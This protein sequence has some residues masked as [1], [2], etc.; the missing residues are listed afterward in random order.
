[1]ENK[2]E[3]KRAKNFTEAEKIMLM[4]ITRE[5]LTIIENRKTD[6]KTVKVKKDTWE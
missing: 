3:V 6:T 2:S 1:M 5:F 4:E